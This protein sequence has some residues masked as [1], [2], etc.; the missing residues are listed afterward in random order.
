[1]YHLLWQSPMLKTSA[2][3]NIFGGQFTLSTQL[4]NQI[5]YTPPLMQCFSLILK[6]LIIII[7]VI[8]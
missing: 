1:M 5:F 3:G 2:L 4:I 6:K 8:M 7:E